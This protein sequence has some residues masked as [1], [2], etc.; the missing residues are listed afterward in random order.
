MRPAARAGSD[1]STDLSRRRV[2]RIRQV[3]LL[4]APGRLRFDQNAQGLAVELPPQ[5]P[6]SHAVCFKLIG[7][8]AEPAR[9]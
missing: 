2:G 3:G 5:R 1:R 6:C 4:G 9:T 7:A 8:I